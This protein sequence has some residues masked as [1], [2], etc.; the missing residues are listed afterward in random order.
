LITTAS[1]SCL[2]DDLVSDPFA[3][4]TRAADQCSDTG[5]LTK[6]TQAQCCVETADL[7]TTALLIDVCSY[8]SQSPSS[9]PS[10]CVKTVFCSNN[11]D[12]SVTNSEGKCNGTCTNIGGVNQCVF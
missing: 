4:L 7:P 6:D 12:C 10:E 8:P 9:N 5:C 2:V 1:S 3:S 11:S